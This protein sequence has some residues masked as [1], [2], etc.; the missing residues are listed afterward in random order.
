MTSAGADLADVLREGDLVMVGCGAGEPTGLL[1]ELVERRHDLPPVRLLL[2]YRL[3][4]VVQPQHLDALDVVVLG[5]YGS[6]ASLVAAG[7]DV[8]PV[9]VADLPGL[10]LDGP[11]RPDVVLLACAPAGPDGRHSLGVTA[12]VVGQ[13]CSVARAV[14]AEVRSAAPR[15][16]G[17]PPLDPSQVTAWTWCDEPLPELGRGSPGPVERAI[18]EH[19]AEQVPD[20]A[21]LQLGIGKVPDAVARA[22][23][24]HRDLGLHSGFLGDW[25]RELVERGVVTNARKP[26][27]RGHTVGGVLMGTSALYAWADD[28][29]DL[30]VRDVR[31]THGADVLARF[32]SLVSVNSAIEVDLGGQ[33]NAEWAGGRYVGAIGGHV[34]YVRAGAL[35][36]RGAGVVALPST[37]RDGRTRIVPRLDDGVVTTARSDVDLVVTEHGVARLRGVSLG[38]R[39]RRLAAIAAPEHREGLARYTHAAREA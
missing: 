13:A 27:D 26:I 22:L 31:H 7:A 21:V 36:P 39:A 19:V 15:T 37:T 28:N 33:V 8:L 29:P 1:R 11:L 10:V 16:R 6:N 20:G 17:H 23:T 35:A 24:G 32:E 9:R 12:D 2:G 5:G 18:A 34:D 3:T 30:E 4:D 25:A 14:V 38:E